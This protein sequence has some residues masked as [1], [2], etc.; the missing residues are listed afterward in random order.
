MKQGYDSECLNH[1]GVKGGD[2]KP[3][4]VEIR[5]VR[6]FIEKN[7]STKAGNLFFFEKSSTV[8]MRKVV[9]SIFFL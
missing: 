1:L 5:V 2:A 7:I 9:V 6:D 8:M 3:G 4:Y